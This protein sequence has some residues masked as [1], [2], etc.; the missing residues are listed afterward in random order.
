FMA[1]AAALALP[2]LADPAT[3]PGIQVFPNASGVL[4]AVN[5][6]GRTRTDGAF[7]QS[8]G[9]NG[10]SCA[11]CHVA[12]QAFTMTPPAIR[13]R[14]ERTRGRAP[15]FAPVD[16][17]NC[18]NAATGDRRAHSLILGNGLIRIGLA[19]PDPAEFTLSV[20]HDPTGCALQFDAKSGQTM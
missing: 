16:G 2:A 8:L 17:A 12:S 5:V 19:L 11:T 10:R 20:V 14:F 7:F 18:T 9:T 1:L 6:N 15:L 13:E 4:A 3:A